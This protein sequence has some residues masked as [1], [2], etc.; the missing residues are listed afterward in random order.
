MDP[1]IVRIVFE[2]SSL[3]IAGALLGA[4]VGWV[5]IGKPLLQ[6]MGV[7][8]LPLFVMVA[9]TWVFTGLLIAAKVVEAWVR[10]K[11]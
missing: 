8:G 1:R 5:F 6:M 4:L 9:G 3:L 10:S 7:M 11:I 2:V